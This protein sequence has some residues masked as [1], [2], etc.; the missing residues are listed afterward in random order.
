MIWGHQDILAKKDH[1]RKIEKIHKDFEL[2]Q[3]FMHNFLGN[4]IP[5]FPLDIL[6]TRRVNTFWCKRSDVSYQRVDVSEHF[7]PKTS[8]KKNWQNSQVFMHAFLSQNV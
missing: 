3:V 1:T 4:Y 7:R 8:Y 5:I 6:L 2:Y